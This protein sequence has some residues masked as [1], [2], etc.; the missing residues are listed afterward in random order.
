[1]GHQPGGADQGGRVEQTVAV[2]LQQ[3]EDGEGAGLAAVG[4]QCLGRGAGQRLGG[5]PC[6]LPALGAVAAQGG[7]RG[8]PPP[9]A[10]APRPAE[11]LA[12]GGEVGAAVA[13]ATVH[14]NGGD[15]PGRHGTPQLLSAGARGAPAIV[16]IASN[17]TG[18]LPSWNAVADPSAKRTFTTPGWVPPNG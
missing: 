9:G 2:P 14:L 5:R 13:E 7:F 11:A 4:G 8:R 10:P 6:L 17:I 16:A 18:G 15:L 1:A 12:H 3:A